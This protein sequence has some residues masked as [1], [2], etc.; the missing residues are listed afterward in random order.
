VKNKK[1]EEE[2]EAVVA[3]VVMVMKMTLTNYMMIWTNWKWDI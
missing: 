1:E 3:A 2:E